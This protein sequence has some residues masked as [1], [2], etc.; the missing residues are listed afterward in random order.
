[1]LW[2]TVLLIILI[3]YSQQDAE[4]Q[5]KNNS[6]DNAAG[7]HV[8]MHSRRSINS[9]IYAYSHKYRVGKKRTIT[10]ISIFT[11]AEVS[12][13][14]TRLVR[15]QAGALFRSC[16]H[17]S[18]SAL[19]VS[20]HSSRFLLQYSAVSKSLGRLWQNCA[21]SCGL[22]SLVLQKVGWSVDVYEVTVGLTGWLIDRLRNLSV[23][24]L[25]LASV[26]DEVEWYQ[27]FVTRHYEVTNRLKP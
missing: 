18:V 7:L 25:L 27:A 16:S 11:L 2:G 20:R 5:N 21:A 10:V 13:C 3:K 15:V 19:A 17:E 8:I 14:P 4:P 22:H 6:W 9:F 23:I 24:Y 26:S 12:P 1:L